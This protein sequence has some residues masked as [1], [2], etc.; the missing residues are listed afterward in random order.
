VLKAT[1]IGRLNI[2]KYGTERRHKNSENMYHTGGT[3][4]VLSQIMNLQTG[5]GGEG[6]GG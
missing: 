1:K 5:T 2:L 6:D 3:R 4:P